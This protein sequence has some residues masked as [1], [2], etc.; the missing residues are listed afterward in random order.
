MDKPTIAFM[1]EVF[2]LGLGAGFEL[3]ILKV[4]RPAIAAARRDLKDAKEC[5]AG[6]EKLQAETRQLLK[7]LPGPA[8]P[9]KEIVN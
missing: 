4:V 9:A 8:K 6:A 7:Q 5:L 3:C 1:V 2:L